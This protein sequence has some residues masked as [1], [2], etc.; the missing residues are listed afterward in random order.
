MSCRVTAAELRML[1]VRYCCK[2]LRKEEAYNPGRYIPTKKN[3][4]V[5]DLYAKLGFEKLN[6]DKNGASTWTLQNERRSVEG[7][8]FEIEISASQN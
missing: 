6:E 3:A 7:L 4:L 5:A 2:R 8:P 1:R